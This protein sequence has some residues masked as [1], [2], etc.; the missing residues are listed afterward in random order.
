VNTQIITVISDLPPSLA[1]SNSGLRVTVTTTTND[2]GSTTVYDTA[3]GNQIYDSIDTFTFSTTGVVQSATFFSDDYN[4]FIVTDFR[5]ISYYKDTGSSWNTDT[6]YELIG[7]GIIQ[8][9][10]SL[11]NIISF[12]SNINSSYTVILLSGNDPNNLNY[13]NSPIITPIDSPNFSYFTV[14]L[15]S[16]YTLAITINGTL[17]YW[18][19]PYGPEPSLLVNEDSM[20]SAS[21]SSDGNTIVSV[22]YSETD[23]ERV[24][25]LYTRPPGGSFLNPTN[26]PLPQLS[27]SDPSFPNAYIAFS[28]NSADTIIAQFGNIYVFKKN[29]VSN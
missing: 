21:I 12:A 1:I 15:A 9:L 28:Q 5:T 24:A 19:Y 27:I 16:T 23:L 29:N 18:D 22:G 17:S 10:S 13:N 2:S 25:L 3:T 7:G 14:S 20:Q 4:L 6:N 26:L 11:E 8:Q